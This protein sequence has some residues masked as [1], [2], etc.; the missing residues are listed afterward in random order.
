MSIFSQSYVTPDE[1]L[2]FLRKTLRIRE[3]HDEILCQ[4]IIDQVAQDRKI[5][6]EP[7]E[8]QTNINQ[9]FLE[10]GL[11]QD[12]DRLLWMNT[13]LVYTEDLEARIYDRLIRQKLSESLFFDPAESF[14]FEHKADFDQAV[15]YQIIVPYERV[16]DDIIHEIRL[17]ELSFYEAAH[18]YDLD[19]RRRH[20]CGYE[21]IF[22]R[23]DPYLNIAE[24]AFGAAPHEVIGPIRTEKGYHLLWVEE[25]IPAEL[26]PQ[27]RQ[28]IIARMFQDWLS[29]ELYRCFPS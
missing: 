9:M 5:F 22:Y 21:G 10:K 26:T 14:F 17:Q 8:V 7:E 29:A 28:E 6:I 19:E 18:L 15:L 20:Q 24:V 1:I 4:K 25:F 13:Q 3:A 23:S 11:E 12:S 16:I 27:I 2:R